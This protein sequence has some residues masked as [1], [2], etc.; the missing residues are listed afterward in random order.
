MWLEGSGFLVTPYTEPSD[1][2][3]RSAAAC[4]VTYVV[5]LRV[6]D[7]DEWMIRWRALIHERTT[8]LNDLKAHCEAASADGNDSGETKMEA[9]E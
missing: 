6:S 1:E 8:A 3:D 5:Q 4:H 2:D 9:K 7:A